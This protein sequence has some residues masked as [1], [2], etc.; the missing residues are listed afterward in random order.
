[1]SGALQAVYQNLRSFGALDAQFNYVTMLLHGDGTNGAQ[2]NT[3]LDSSTNAFTI[4][5]T[6]NTTQGSFSPYG[7]N[8]S[9]YFATSYLY[10]ANNAALSFGTGDFCVEAWVFKLSASYG[11]II[12]SRAGNTA[13]PWAVY[14][15]NSNFPYFYQGSELTSTIA[16]TL[17]AWNH[18]AVTRSSGTLKIFVNGVQG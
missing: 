9:N 11:S 3:F 1:M 8:W 13:T 14:I 7:S 16:I 17:N 6:G 5:R 2:N 18:V 10:F 12:D 4:T 15:D